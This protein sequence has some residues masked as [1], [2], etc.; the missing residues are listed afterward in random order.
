MPY[1][2]GKYQYELVAGWAK[3]PEGWTFLTPF[4]P[5]P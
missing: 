1:G 5:L 4:I 2:S 3:L